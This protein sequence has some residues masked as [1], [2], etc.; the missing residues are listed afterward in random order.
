MIA[1]SDLLDNNSVVFGREIR[2]R[3]LGLSG[4]ILNSR[5]I[6]FDRI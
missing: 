2:K 4:G 1:K 5:L 3:S 6:D